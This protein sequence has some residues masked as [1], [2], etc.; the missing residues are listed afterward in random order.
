MKNDIFNSPIFFVAFSSC[1]FIFFF[2]SFILRQIRIRNGR[3]KIVEGRVISI[4]DSF[5]SNRSIGQKGRD[6][7]VEYY[8][9]GDRYTMNIG[10]FSGKTHGNN[11]FSRISRSFQ[12]GEKVILLYDVKNPKIVFRKSSPFLYLGMLISS[13]ILVFSVVTMIKL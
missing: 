10:G 13:V 7:N 2:G 5:A 8:I 9:D 1:F 3:Y 12:L 11:T 6:V 4:E